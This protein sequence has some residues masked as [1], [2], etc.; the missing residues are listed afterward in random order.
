MSEL[1]DLLQVHLDGLNNHDLIQSRAS[2]AEDVVTVT[3]GGT[4]EGLDAFM[5][6]GD[7]FMTAAPDQW[8]TAEHI[9]EVGDTI[10]SEGVYGGTHTGP[11]AT[12][13]GVIPA[14]GRSFQFPYCEVHQVRD[15]K[16]VHTRI[17]WDNMGFMAQLGLLG[18]PAS[19]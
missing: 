6:L 16:F 5:A 8:I 9:Y 11:L 12:P 1:R 2:F 4:M 18:E 15:G 7:A 3:P 17:Y 13:D 14:T 19:A 10:I